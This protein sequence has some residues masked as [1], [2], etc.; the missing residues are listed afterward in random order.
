MNDVE[1]QSI[2]ELLHT[3]KRETLESVAVQLLDHLPVPIICR[4]CELTEEQVLALVARRM[5]LEGTVPR[6]QSD[7]QQPHRVKFLDQPISDIKVPMAVS[8]QH[9]IQ[10]HKE[11]LAKLQRYLRG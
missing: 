10:K 1:N 5:E 3:V 7:R 2:G 6:E 9:A 11:A 4:V 8:T